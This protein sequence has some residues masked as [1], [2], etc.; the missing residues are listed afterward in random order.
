MTSTQQS[1]FCFRKCA[2]SN[3]TEH[4]F[5]KFL[6]HGTLV[7]NTNAFVLDVIHCRC[8][9]HF[10]KKNCTDQ[11]FENGTV[12]TTCESILK[13]ASAHIDPVVEFWE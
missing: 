3:F 13:N 4:N 12:V 8:T 10:G 6:P 2:D 9:V 5:G 7:C 11:A 1:R